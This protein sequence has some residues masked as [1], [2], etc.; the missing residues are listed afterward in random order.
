ML[1]FSGRVS[2]GKLDHFHFFLCFI[3]NLKAECIAIY[4]ETF[5]LLGSISNGFKS[6]VLVP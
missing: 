5:Y 1:L 2:L 4:H 3:G 6:S